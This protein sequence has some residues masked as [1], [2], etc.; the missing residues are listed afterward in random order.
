MKY[1][2]F[3][4]RA[5]IVFALHFL[6]QFI[7]WA[8]ADSSAGTKIPWGIISFPLFYTLRSWAALYFWMVGLL[9]SALWGLAAGVVTRPRQ[10]ETL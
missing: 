5:G 9:N 10:R 4:I 6:I 8:L 2:S 1:S 7:A 3:R